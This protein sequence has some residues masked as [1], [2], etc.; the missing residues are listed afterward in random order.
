MG[1]DTGSKMHTQQPPQQPQPQQ[2]NSSNSSRS[3]SFH[4]LYQLL[5]ASQYR[6][7]SGEKAAYSWSPKNELFSESQRN[8]TDQL[9]IYS[10]GDILQARDQ[11]QRKERYEYQHNDQAEEGEE[12]AIGQESMSSKYHTPDAYSSR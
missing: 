6:Y 2:S 10:L 11:Q 12:S 7:R 1:I 8:S 9:D 3:S 4:Q 5:D